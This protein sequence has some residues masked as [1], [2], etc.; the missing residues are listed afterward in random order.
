MRIWSICII[1][2]FVLIPRFGKANDSEIIVTGTGSAVVVPDFATLEIHIQFVS[3]K[4]SDAVKM[5]ASLYEKIINALREFGLTSK[6]IATT[7]YSVREHWEMKKDREREFVGYMARHSILIRISKLD[8]VGAVI[9]AAVNAGANR[10]GGL[11][12]E[13]SKSDSVHLSAL[14]AA[15][16]QARKRA[17]IMAKASGGRVGSL[18]ELTTEAPMRSSMPNDM[19]ISEIA[20]ETQL[21][22]GDHIV[23]VRVLGR[24]KFIEGQ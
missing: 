24:W 16:Q 3:E 17:E 21:S 19:T 8:K 13:S 18:I 20:T 1:I 2:V 11:E 14:A 15:V 10:I 4:A 9:D 6:Q 12:F 5:T 22:P 23:R 7:N